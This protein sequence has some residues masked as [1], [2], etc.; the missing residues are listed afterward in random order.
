MYKVKRVDV[1]KV[2]LSVDRNGSRLLEIAMV[3][4]I[5]FK[6]PEIIYYN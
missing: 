1:N 3:L 6:T 4:E 2:A 5:G